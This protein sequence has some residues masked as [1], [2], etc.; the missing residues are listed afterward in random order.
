VISQDEMTVSD[1]D[2]IRRLREHGDLFADWMAR[3]G[4]AA[5]VVRPDRY[6]YGVAHERDGLN[7]LIAGMAR[8]IIG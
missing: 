8:H 4:A 5:A 1:H 2:G 3:N 7:Q 6:V